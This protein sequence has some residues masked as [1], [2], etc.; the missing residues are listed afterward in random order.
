MASRIVFI[1][2]THFGAGT[3]GFQ[4]QPRRVDLLPEI[5]AGLPRADLV[6]HG[7][8][9]VDNGTPMEIETALRFLGELKVPVAYCLGNHDLGTPNAFDLW[10]KTPHPPN[11]QRANCVVTL[12][13]VDVILVNN[14]WLTG[15]FWQH[16]TGGWQERILPADLVWLEAALVG[17]RPAILVVHTP[18]DPIPP[19][20]TGLAEAIHVAFPDYVALVNDLVARHPRVRLVLSGHNHVTLATRHDDRWRLT[21]SALSE[22][23]FEFRVIECDR[24]AIRVDTGPAL[25]PLPDVAYDA[26]RAWV[27]GQ[28]VDRQLIVSW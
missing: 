9:L 25:R 6:V 20:L 21:T 12:P 28:A 5:W 4:Q 23:P 15:M 19:R 16:G 26:A 1:T 27:N 24:R 11:V 2:D 14:G 3:T 18:P 8:D 17:E 10:Q 22:P 7:G 13:D